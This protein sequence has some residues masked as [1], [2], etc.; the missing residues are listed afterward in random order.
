MGGIAMAD[1]NEIKHDLERTVNGVGRELTKLG[2]TAAT[3]LKLNSLKV[4]LCELYEELG[5]ISY[6]K[7][8]DENSNDIGDIADLLKK[9][10]DKIKLIKTIEEELADK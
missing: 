1:W 9:I 2:N 4:E 10:D 7:L 6:K 5:R 3:K 8:R